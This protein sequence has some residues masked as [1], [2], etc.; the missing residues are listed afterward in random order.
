MITEVGSG[1]RY[2][3]KRLFSASFNA[4]VFSKMLVNA[5]AKIVIVISFAYERSSTDPCILKQ[6]KAQVFDED[7]FHDRMNANFRATS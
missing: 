4:H 3:S 2:F 5:Y 6:L 7:K 1:R